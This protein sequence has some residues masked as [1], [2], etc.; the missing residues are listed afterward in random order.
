MGTPA[1]D[2][3]HAAVRTDGARE[4]LTEDARTQGI[5]GAS[6]GL[7]RTGYKL[8]L[9]LSGGNA[10]GAYQ[11]GAFQ[12]LVEH[13]ASIDWVIGGSTGAVNGAIIC[14]NTPDISLQRLREYWQ[15][16]KRDSDTSGLW[17]GFAEDA[18]RTLAAQTT[19]AMGQPHV[20]VPRR[21]FGPWWEPFGNR[22]PSSLYDTAPLADT[23]PRFVDFDRLNSGAIRFSATAVELEAGVDVV[24]DTSAMWVQ[25]E[26]LRASS[27]L[28][29]AFP[30]VEIGGTLFAD[31]GASANLP[32]DVL[33]ADPPAG[34]TLCLAV[35]LLPLRAPPP[36]TLG[37]AAER[38][39]DLMFATQSRRA[40]EGWKRFYDLRQTSAV[41]DDGMA[42]VTLVHL[43]Y[44]AQEP[45]VCGKAFDFSPE[46]SGYRW[47]QGY[48]D[49]ENVLHRLETGEIA[50]GTL[51]LAVHRFHGQ[52]EI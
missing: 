41:P 45:E 28:L 11:A 34:P 6:G 4:K 21:L 40:I 44:G 10:L 15:P 17:T 37:N 16:G 2:N 29:P 39:Q 12:S 14:G 49:M 43:A 46:S 13:G 1:A 32:I 26:H 25:S 20:F 36:K 35:D 48:L 5:T 19:L 38:M 24:F 31:A 51:G 8:V 7:T 50:V 30:P 33:L 27:A 47:E 18:R 23:L 9:V 3:G 42:A 52:E 22:E